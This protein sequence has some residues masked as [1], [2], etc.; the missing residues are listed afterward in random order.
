[1]EEETIE[2]MYLACDNSWDRC[3]QVLALAWQPSPLSEIPPPQPLCWD[4]GGGERRGG[5]RERER[6]EA[7]VSTAGDTRTQVPWPKPGITKGQSNSAV[8]SRL[9]T[10]CKVNQI[11]SKHF[12]NEQRCTK[13]YFP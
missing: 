12:F 8:L 10:R 6:E 13:L 11:K 9:T 3:F 4:R 7:R 1:M 2:G 5:E